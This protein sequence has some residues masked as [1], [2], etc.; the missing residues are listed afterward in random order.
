MKKTPLTTSDSSGKKFTVQMH[1]L[2]ALLLSPALNI[3]EMDLLFSF[4]INFS[5]LMSVLLVLPG[6]AA[7]FLV[8]AGFLASW[9]K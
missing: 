9:F 2:S 3:L 6:V 4:N 1:D 8:L 5:L 7:F